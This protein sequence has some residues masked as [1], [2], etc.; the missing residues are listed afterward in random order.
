MKSLACI[1]VVLW[2]ASTAWGQALCVTVSPNP[3]PQGASITISGFAASPNG[4]YSQA[5]CF[6]PIIHSGTPNGPVIQALPCAFVPTP[7]PGCGSAAPPR[8]YTWTPGPQT[9][10]GLYWFEIDWVS[11]PFG[12]PTAEF[13]GVTIQGTP[14]GP[15]LSG[16]PG[17]TWGTPYF[18]A[19]SAPAHPGGGYAVA[20]SGSTNTGLPLGPGLFLSL[21]VDAI[22]NLTFPTPDPAIF[23]GFQGALDGNGA[24]SGIA[25]LIPPLF[26][27]CVPLHAQAAVI[28]AAGIALS[29]EYTSRSSRPD[30]NAREAAHLPPL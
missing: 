13:H 4:L 8:S 22:F 2:V 24:A 23:V 20:L 6:V 28:A 26:F 19:L 9:A 5:S 29:N 25:I 11:V 7:I 17:A 18:L 1:A 3:A 10:P 27:G 30:R 21:D 16:A 12:A 15:V 14:P